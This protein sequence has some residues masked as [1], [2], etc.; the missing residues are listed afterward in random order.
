MGLEGTFPSVECTGELPPNLE[1]PKFYSQ[2]RSAYRKSFNA[3]LRLEIPET[4][5]TNVSRSEFFEECQLAALNLRKQLNLWLNSEHFRPIK[6]RM[7]EKLSPTEIIRIIIQTE[8]SQ[9]QRLPWT[10]WDLCERYPKAEIALSSPTYELLSQPI[11]NRGTV[12]IL[13][14]LGDSTGIDVRKDQALL[15]QLPDAEVKF[16]VESQRQVLN[17]E[18]WN[19]PW[20]ILFFAGHSSTIPDREVAQIHLNKN[21]TLTC[22]QQ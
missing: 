20:D 12:R 22:D 21:D 8:S 7:L 2:W 14:I 1:I 17:D 9:L 13:A 4:Q 11:S 10:L 16:L 5:V 18:L 6:E 3:S 19:Q 15:E